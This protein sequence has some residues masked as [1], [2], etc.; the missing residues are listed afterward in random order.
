MIDNMVQSRSDPVAKCAAMWKICLKIVKLRDKS[1]DLSL[2]Y[3]AV[4]FLSHRS[5]FN[6]R[7]ASRSLRKS[8]Q[9]PILSVATVPSCLYLIVNK[10]P[11]K[12]SKIVVIPSTN[13]SDFVSPPALETAYC[14]F[15]YTIIG[16]KSAIP[17]TIVCFSLP[18]PAE[19]LR[20]QEFCQVI[21]L[22]RC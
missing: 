15:T 10:I 7:G 19:D 8:S 21:P 6:Q 2:N 4:R 3:S 22:L 16:I 14:A 13:I 5:F 11:T 18:K 17:D 12:I 20:V 9:L 1:S